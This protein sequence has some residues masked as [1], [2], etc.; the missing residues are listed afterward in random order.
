MSS[1]GESQAEATQSGL[2]LSVSRNLNQS[3]LAMANVNVDQSRAIRPPKAYRPKIDGDF[4]QWVRHLEHYFILLNIDN[5][6][7]TTMLLYKLGEEALLTAFHLGLTDASDYDVANQALMQYFSPVETPEELRTKFHQ[8]FQSPDESLEHYAME[9]R[10]FI[11]KAYPT[12]IEDVLEEKAKQQF[13]LSVRNSITLERL[14]VT[15]PEKLKDAIEFARLSEVAGK[16][17][18][19]NPPPSNK[20]VF[21]AMPFRNSDNSRTRNKFESSSSNNFSRNN[22]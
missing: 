11:S 14:I 10:V 4:K 5:A 7:K 17:A 1:P 13:I 21:V 22:V 15:R 3:S 16:T 19:G 8:R 20:N 18:R 6:S 12:M 2:S 9:L